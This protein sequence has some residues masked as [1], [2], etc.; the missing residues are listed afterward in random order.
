MATYNTHQK[1]ILL[2]FLREN[3]DTPMGIDELSVRLSETCPDAPGKS[4]IYRLIGQLV[5]KGTVKRFVKGNSRQFLYQLAGSE[6][7]HSHLHLK[8]TE[9]GKLLHMGH[10]LSEKM[11]SDILGESDFS[12]KVDSTTLFGC[13]K[14]C[15][16]KEG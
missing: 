7:C 1:D 12:V 8:C 9:C 10:T 13:C 14:D 11:L 16:I 6:E 2:S 3:K 4:T 15:R 5:E